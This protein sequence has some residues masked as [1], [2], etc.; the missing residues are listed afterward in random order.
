AY[1]EA[2]ARA[3]SCAPQL[4]VEQCNVEVDDALACPCPTFAESGNTEALAKLDELKKEWDA[5]QCGAV[6]DCPAIACV[7]PKGASCDPG[8]NPQDGGHCSDLE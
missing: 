7:E 6:I 2:L 4:P 3:K 8:T 1:Q 5:A